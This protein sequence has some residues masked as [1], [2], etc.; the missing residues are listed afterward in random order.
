MTKSLR[1]AIIVRT[2][3]KNIYYRLPTDENLR[4]FKKQR[5]YCVKLL[6]KS[7]MNF[8]GNINISKITDNRKL[9][10]I[11]TPFFST[12]T[13]S[14]SN[15]I[16]YEND[17]IIRNEG[18]VAEKLNTYFSNVVQNLNIKKVENT[19]LISEHREDPIFKAIHK[20][21][22]HPSIITINENSASEMRFSFNTATQLG[23][24]D[25]INDFDVRK[26]TSHRNIP[27][28]TFKQNIDLYLDIIV[29]NSITECN[30]PDLLK[31][32]DITPAFKK[33]RCYRQE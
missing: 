7:K 6:N 18:E 28:K 9:W 20:Y 31:L 17:E 15:F 33:R 13:I 29:N 22:K 1:K 12:K 8:Y 3:L 5:N 23:V 10:K 32:A 27:S 24:V 11:I 14:A 30:F 25:V 16:L 21:S 26:A 4:I 2:K 19:V